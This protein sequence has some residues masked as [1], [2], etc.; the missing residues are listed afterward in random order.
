[1]RPPMAA[2]LPLSPNDERA[3]HPASLERSLGDFRL[4]L[5]SIRD[6][7]V[8]MLDPG[9]EIL[10]WTE[11]ARQIHGFDAED[12][13]H[14]SF[15]HLYRPVDVENGKPERDLR[16]ALAN[17][18]HHE[19]AWRVREDG[20]AF[21]A[22]VDLTAMRAPGERSSGSARSRAISPSGW[23]PRTATGSSSTA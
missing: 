4:L 14:R 12:V 17:G 2:D 15:E 6:H 18:S 21:W 11:G 5:D 1:M 3:S 22:S 20:V 7:A 9:G 10:T 13:V 8:I 16:R 23:K 19:E